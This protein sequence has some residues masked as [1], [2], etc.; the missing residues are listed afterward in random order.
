[1]IQ[2]LNTPLD[3]SLPVSFANAKV[4]EEKA[5]TRLLREK[6]LDAFE[7]AELPEDFILDGKDPANPTQRRFPIIRF[8]TGFLQLERGFFRRHYV[9]VTFRSFGECYCE[10][11]DYE[12]LIVAEGRYVKNLENKVK[13]LTSQH[14]CLIIDW[15]M[16]DGMAVIEVSAEDQIPSP[17]PLLDFLANY[18]E[19]EQVAFDLNQAIDGAVAEMASLTPDGK[20]ALYN[21]ALETFSG[22]SV[23]PETSV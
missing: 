2:N 22:A 19:S 8:A 15:T 3:A 23:A 7:E 17:A 18:F 13:G 10:T 20:T 16:G 11:I 1:M 9:C 4:Y 14:E 12:T 5:I 21:K 6:G